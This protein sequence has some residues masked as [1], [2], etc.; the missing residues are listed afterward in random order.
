MM[1]ALEGL[2]LPIFTALLFIIS[3][4]N[5]SIFTEREIVTFV[6]GFGSVGLF[7]PPYNE[8]FLRDAG[9]GYHRN[10]ILACMAITSFTMFFFVTIQ[11]FKYESKIAFS[12][13][14]VSFLLYIER[15][16]SSILRLR[17]VRRQYLIIKY[18]FI[19][20]TAGCFY[21]FVEYQLQ[22]LLCG[23]IT[24]TCFSYVELKKQDNEVFQARRKVYAHPVLHLIFLNSLGVMIANFDIAFYNYQSSNVSDEFVLLFFF[25]ISSVAAVLFTTQQY[26]NSFASMPA[27]K[28]LSTK[29]LIIM[30]YYLAVLFIFAD[31]IEVHE[32]FLA[33]SYF[34]STILIPLWGQ[35]MLVDLRPLINLQSIFIVLII[36]CVIMN[37]EIEIIR[38][39][40]FALYLFFFLYLK[41]WK[42]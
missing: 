16:V 1:R 21:V 40:G 13:C 30:F 18:L 36:V 37:V 38:F 15:S 32:I 7:L 26:A 8:F 28:S 4:I 35:Q 9:H 42:S 41:R 31:E 12:L 29:L 27:F 11:L 39:V 2:L 24:T 17:N 33:A 23:L 20:F 22:V 10:L 14:L 25:K 19:F 5:G 3:Q 34:L 6:I